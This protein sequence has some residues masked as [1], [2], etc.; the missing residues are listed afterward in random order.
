MELSKVDNANQDFPSL[1]WKIAISSL[2]TSALAAFARYPPTT[3]KQF[4][5]LSLLLLSLVFSLN[6]NLQVLLQ[7]HLY[8]PL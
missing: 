3:S 1:G 6:S 2:T 7:R 4:F 8:E 5:L